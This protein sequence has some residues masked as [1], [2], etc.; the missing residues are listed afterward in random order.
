MLHQSILMVLMHLFLDLYLMEILHV[1]KLIVFF[2]T[3]NL[4]FAPFLVLKENKKPNLK[5]VWIIELTAKKKH[6]GKVMVDKMLSPIFSFFE[7]KW[8]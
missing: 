3:R 2:S 1:H 7:I 8:G 5:L 4:N 6:M